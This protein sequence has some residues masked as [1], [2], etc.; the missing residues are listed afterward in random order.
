MK[1]IVLPRFEVPEC[2][3]GKP[4]TGEAFQA[5]VQDNVER[6][7]RTGQY[8]RLRDHPTRIPVAERFVLEP[9]APRRAG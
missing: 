7:R 9:D 1:W 6:L 8:E 2:L 4:M 5:W 3:P